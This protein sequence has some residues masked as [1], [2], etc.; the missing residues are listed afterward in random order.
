MN[1]WKHFQFGGRLVVAVLSAL[2]LA[3]CL[4][5]PGSTQAV[6]SQVTV[7]IPGTLYTGTIH[8]G[9]TLSLAFQVSIADAN[10]IGVTVS[11]AN[12]TMQVS[13]RCPNGSSQTL[14]AKAPSQSLLMPA[15][16]SGWF[17]LTV[18]YQAKAIAPLTLCGGQGGVETAVTFTATSSMRCDVLS[19]MGCC[20]KV[21]HRFHHKHNDE[22]PVAES[23]ECDTEKECESGD[24]A[25]CCHT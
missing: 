13:V 4:A 16:N 3:L 15:S 9:D 24:T 17:P 1:T 19:T 14:T 7:A 2:I 5:P 25:G 12:P 21:C 22:A 23:E 6:S 18:T 11:M 10:P 20:H 8:P